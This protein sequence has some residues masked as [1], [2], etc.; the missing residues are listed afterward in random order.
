[1]DVALGKVF[2]VGELQVQLGQP[3]QHVLSGT[4]KLL[5]LAGEM[6]VGVER[7]IH[8]TYDR[9]CPC[10]RPSVRPSTFSLRTMAAALRC[11]AS[12]RPLPSWTV[13]LS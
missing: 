10:L 2:H 5:P 13:S 7:K 6:L 3:H 4:F 1:M 12:Q 11:S 8:F 9:S